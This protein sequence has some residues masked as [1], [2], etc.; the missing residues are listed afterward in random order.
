MIIN[1]PYQLHETLSNIM[2]F[3][4]HF[5]SL[6]DQWSYTLYSCEKLMMDIRNAI[7]DLEIWPFE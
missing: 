6:Q 4:N 5:V 1:Q 2:G 3:I 7:H